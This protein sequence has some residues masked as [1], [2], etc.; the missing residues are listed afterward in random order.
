[1][2]D[3]QNQERTSE[4]P[5]RSDVRYVPVEYFPENHEDDE[6]DLI[7]LL[8][9]LWEDRKLIYL[10][11]LFFTCIGVFYYLFA[12][13]EYESGAIL[14]QEQ[15]Q[16]TGVASMQLLQQPGFSS[17]QMVRQEG[18]PPSIYPDIIE[19]ADF[20]LGVINHEVYFE[21]LDRRVTPLVYFNEY[22]DP[23]L[24]QK[25]TG[26]LVDYTIRL[27]VTLYRGFRNLFRSDEELLVP[28][29]TFTDARFLVLNRKQRSAISEVRNRIEIVMSGS[30][31]TFNTRMPDR[32]ASA[33][34]NHYV[35]ERIQEFV[36]D[37]R[38]GNYRQNLEFIERQTEEARQRYEEAQL[39]LARFSDRNVSITTAVA[40]TQQEDL[41][42]RRNITYN[43]YNTL[44]QELE[45]SRIRLQEETPIFNVLQKPSLPTSAEGKPILAIVVAI[46]LGGVMGVISVFGRRGYRVL[47]DALYNES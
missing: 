27:P 14:I 37:Y 11:T 38:I 3:E 28:A 10:V 24:T 6:I 20:L 18:L 47:S 34:L 45:Q 31:V 33:E 43:V 13:R 25:A 12:P 32:Q 22:Y 1:M 5:S 9:T 17:A 44:A 21:K 42:N 4:K 35:I 23:P 26:L 36:I 15:Q 19:S 2:S 40:R 41:L 30:L 8:R 16:A 39:E 46:L 29:S 7:E